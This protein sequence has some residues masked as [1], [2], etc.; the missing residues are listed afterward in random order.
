MLNIHKVSI[1]FQGDYL[2][3]DLTFRLGNGDRVG[4]VGKNGSENQ[5]Y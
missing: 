3:Q 2:F 1:S 5:H 4:L